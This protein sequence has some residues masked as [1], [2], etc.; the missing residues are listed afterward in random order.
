MEFGDSIKDDN[1]YQGLDASELFQRGKD[2]FAANNYMEAAECFSRALEAKSRD[3]EPNDPELGKFYLWFADALLTKEE[4]NQ[5]V[6]ADE[7]NAR[8]GHMLPKAEEVQELE[9]QKQEH[10]EQEDEKSDEEIAFEMFQLAFGCFEK[11]YPSAHADL[12]EDVDQVKVEVK[13]EDVI[14][15]SYCLVRLGDMH[16]SNSD[17]GDA[18]QVRLIVDGDA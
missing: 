13:E 12:D 18:A 7:I 5:Q 16:L 2:A 4:Q 15:G 8:G 9:S 10:K 6:L 1:E 14:D 11:L 17:F 3:L